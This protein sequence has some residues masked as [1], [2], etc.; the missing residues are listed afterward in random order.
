[1]K[2]DSI[3]CLAERSKEAPPGSLKVTDASFRKFFEGLPRREQELATLCVF[4]AT[5]WTRELLNGF[6]TEGDSEMAGKARQRLA[7]LVS[8]ESKL[9]ICL[10]LHP[11]AALPNLNQP[12]SESAAPE[13]FLDLTATC[14]APWM[15]SGAAA[16][17]WAP[18]AT[19]TL[20]AT[21]SA[22]RATVGV[23][24]LPVTTMAALLAA[25]GAGGQISRH[26]RRRPPPPPCSGC[27]RRRQGGA[28]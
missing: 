25:W 16:R 2:K 22:R 20:P 14:R 26:R 10:E 18:T 12:L 17:A 24:V 27:A 1:M 9:D 19:P 23:R 21:T 13:R 28:S 5:N 8:L 11:T 4:L 15:P 3:T 7:D 6:C